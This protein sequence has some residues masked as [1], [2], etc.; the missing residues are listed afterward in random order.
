M[1]S[2]IHTIFYAAVDGD[3]RTYPLD[4]GIM[5]AGFCKAKLQS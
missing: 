2:D 1:A 3:K 5:K 4:V